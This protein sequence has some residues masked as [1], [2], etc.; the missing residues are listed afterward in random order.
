M[1]QPHT[2]ITQRAPST[3]ATVR[4]RR[5]RILGTDLILCRLS[6]QS[7]NRSKVN[8]E[9]TLCCSL[10]RCGHH[11][12]GILRWSGSGLVHHNADDER[13]YWMQFGDLGSVAVALVLALGHSTGSR[14]SS[15]QFC[16][17]GSGQGGVAGLVGIE[18]GVVSGLSNPND[19][20]VATPVE[21]TPWE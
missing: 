12:V 1:R 17:C 20:G 2:G 16:L 13:S 6:G 19:S 14:G 7:T 4:H 3:G 5:I 9:S 11:R 21:T 18:S 10:R 8:A 15:L